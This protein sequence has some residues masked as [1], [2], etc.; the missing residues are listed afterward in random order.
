MISE[1]NRAIKI[2]SRLRTQ[3]PYHQ[4]KGYVHHC[5]HRKIN[6]KPIESFKKLDKW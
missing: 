4:S 1:K 6:A 3:D 5:L 2:L